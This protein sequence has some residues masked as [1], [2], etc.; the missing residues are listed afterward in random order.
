MKKQFNRL[1]MAM[2]GLM[3]VSL[4]S[5][6]DEEIARTLEGTWKG[7]IFRLAIIAWTTTDSQV[8][9]MIMGI[10]LH[11]TFIM[12]VVQITQVIIGGMIVGGILPEWQ[13]IV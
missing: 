11:S 13:L 3:A 2:L 4:T 1:L 7:D 6:D 8:T 10:K 9:S 12:L 5:C